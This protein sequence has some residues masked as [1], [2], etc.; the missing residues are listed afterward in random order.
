MLLSHAAAAR[1]LRHSRDMAAKT[2]PFIWRLRN[3]RDLH[4]GGVS[5]AVRRLVVIIGYHIRA[6]LWC[7]D[8]TYGYSCLMQTTVPS[9]QCLVGCSVCIQ[10]GGYRLYEYL[11]EPRTIRVDKLLVLSIYGMS[12]LAECPS[13]RSSKTDVM[14]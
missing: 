3:H 5:V 6:V 13:R 2:G 7:V 14:Q 12:H 11:G 1:L 9:C 8:E 10:H 4:D